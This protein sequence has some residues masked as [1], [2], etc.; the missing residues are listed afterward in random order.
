MRAVREEQVVWRGKERKSWARACDQHFCIFWH[1][2]RRLF[3]QAQL[4]VRSI[5]GGQGWERKDVSTSLVAVYV[6]D[7][8]AT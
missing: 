6:H 5:V 2:V 8:V 7:S 1:I 4:F 3:G